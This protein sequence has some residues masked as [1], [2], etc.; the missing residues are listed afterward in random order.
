[1]ECGDVTPLLFFLFMECGDVTP[2]FFLF[3]ECGDVTP[4][5]F[6][7]LAWQRAQTKNREK[8]RKTKKQERCY[9]TALHKNAISKRAQGVL[10]RARLF[11]LVGFGCSQGVRRSRFKTP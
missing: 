7:W 11:R 2:L 10:N 1:M 6:L 4:L 8:T 5:L 9:I 3:M